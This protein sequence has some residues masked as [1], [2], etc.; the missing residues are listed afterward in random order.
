MFT[1]TCSEYADLVRYMRG[2]G[3]VNQAIWLADLNSEHQWF[4]GS[5]SHPIKIWSLTALQT[6][7]YATVP[8]FLIRFG[9]VSGSSLVGFSVGWVK[10]FILC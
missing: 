2:N 3:W 4:T 5:S 1:Q 10:P 7:D 8:F 6:T 9:V